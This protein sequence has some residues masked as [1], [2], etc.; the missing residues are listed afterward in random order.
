MIKFVSRLNLA[1]SRVDRLHGIIKGVSLIALGEARG[2]GKQVDQ[3]TLETVRECASKYSN[4]L[5]VK[6]NPNTFTH[7]AGSLAGRIPPDSIRIEGNKTIGD[8][9]LYN[10]LPE[11]TRDYLFEIA[12]ETPENI[13]LSIEFSGDDEKIGENNFARC[14]EI[15]A[16]TIVDLPAA[17]P[18]GLFAE[19]NGDSKKP[20]GDVE[21]ADP[22]YQD[23]GQKRYPLD[24]EDHVRAAWSYIN[25]EDNAA[26]YSS[27][28]L[29]KVKN[30]IKTALKKHGA[31]IAE[32]K[33][34]EM[35]MNDET[36]TKLATATATATAKAVTDALKPIIQKFQEGNG[37]GNNDDEEEKKKKK[38]GE[39]DTEESE[40]MAA[41]VTASDDEATK[42]K[43]LE[44]YRASQ[45]TKS[46]AKM[47]GSEL[48]ALIQRSNMQFFRE[49]GNRPARN[50]AEPS[51]GDTDPFEARV[52]QHMAAGAKS[53]G[54]AIQRAR[55]DSPKDYNEW[56]AKKHPNVQH[57]AVK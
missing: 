56:M 6:F 48:S 47:T 30:K 40:E 18:T 37:N 25:H 8:L 5:R 27:D 32:E 20:Y 9:Y 28:E 24:T 33:D 13:G 43:K 44:T 41:G 34:E 7:G 21:Y 45:G 16:A 36:I 53:R 3:K 49:T 54:L 39:N 31:E 12:E 19:D 46:V 14:S 23:D 22:G 57:M 11:A 52:T 10:A 26:K 50:N 15:Y 4:G 38:E 51:R 17:N 35:D 2:H 29:T 1:G 55:R 42:Q